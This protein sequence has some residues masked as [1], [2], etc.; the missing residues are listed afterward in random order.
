VE[1][2]DSFLAEFQRESDRAAAVLGAAYLDARL[3]ALL[4]AK[5]VAVPKFVEELL[6]GQG[7]LAS[8]SARISVCYAVGLIS[9]NAAE[10]LHTIRRIRN[11]FAHKSHGV[12]FDTP[13][14]RNRVDSLRILGALKTSD[15][16]GVP[17]PPEPRKRFNLAVALLLVAAIE[18]RIKEQ[19]KFVELAGSSVITVTKDEE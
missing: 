12:S 19:A 2:F 7:G 9:L 16:S 6:T 11:D 14:I 8:F 4:R 5:L 10:D 3:E 18:K 15:G 17:L 1:D 13:S